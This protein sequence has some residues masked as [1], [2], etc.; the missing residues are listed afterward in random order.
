MQPIVT[1]HS[2]DIHF[3]EVRFESNCYAS[4]ARKV[5]Q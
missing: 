4:A 2:I 5:R 3:K 1:L